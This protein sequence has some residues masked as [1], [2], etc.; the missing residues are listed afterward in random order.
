MLS[1]RELAAEHVECIVRLVRNRE[2]PT[3][4]C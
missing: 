2:L 1:D 3:V 4:R